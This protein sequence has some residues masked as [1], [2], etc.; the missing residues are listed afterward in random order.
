L[1]TRTGGQT[2]TEFALVVPMLILMV[3]YGLYFTELVR[4]KL[5]LQEASR[6]LA[7]EMSS[8]PLDDFATANHDQAFE[9]ARQ[10]VSK[11]A[12]ARYRDLDSV[13]ERPLGGWVVGY[14]D[15][16]ATIAN[17]EAPV[18]DRRLPEPPTNAF[19]APILAVLNRPAS[20]TY[21]AF[22]LN[23]R[24]RIEAEVSLQLDNR[25]LPRSVLGRALDF[26]L[27]HR[28]TVLASGWQLADG[29]DADLGRPSGLQAQVHRMHL[30][31]A[32]SLLNPSTVTSAVRKLIGDAVPD[33]IHNAYVVSHNYFAPT[34]PARVER[35]CDQD[36]KHD[37]P[38]GMSNLD[39]A[40]GP[41]LDNE[42]DGRAGTGRRKCY[43]T[44]PFRDTSR[45][46]ESLYRRLYLR[47]GPYFMGCKKA[48]ADNPAEKGTPAF[49]EKD[50]HKRKVGCEE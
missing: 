11:E 37:A 32:P 14:R 3:L 31:G 30:L 1:K 44:A 39:R 21:A 9:R 10:S 13:D 46:A 6:F 34:D 8:H 20:A 29:S 7:W 15:F 45:Y 26:R 42:E 47:R 36:P 49:S 16:G 19:I 43:D 50:R 5:K 17:L 33:P 2:T 22:K 27:T 18:F 35:G 38:W 4:A 24:G 28:F 41:R 23:P 12:V 40:D 25:L 48:Q